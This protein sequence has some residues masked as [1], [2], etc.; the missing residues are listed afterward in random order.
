VKLDKKIEEDNMIKIE[1]VDQE[2]T[3]GMMST[4]NTT[5]KDKINIIYK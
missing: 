3:K 2:D 5:K 4:R 1:E